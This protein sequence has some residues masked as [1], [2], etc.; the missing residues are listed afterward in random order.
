MITEEQI[1]QEIDTFLEHFGKKGMH[2]GQRSKKSKAAIGVGGYVVGSGVTHVIMKR[3]GNPAVALIAG[4]AAAVAGG[5]VVG[6]ILDSRKS[7]KK[8][9]S[10]LKSSG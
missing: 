8:K 6:K 9:I 2:W 10:E 3:T 4:G 7:S 5:I 1:D